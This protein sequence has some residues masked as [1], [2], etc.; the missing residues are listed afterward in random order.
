MKKLPILLASVLLASARAAHAQTP[1][2]PPQVAETQAAPAPASAGVA[3]EKFNFR[4][5][6]QQ[7]GS[8][9]LDL[10]A[11]RTTVGTAQAQN[12]LAR[13]FPDPTVTAG[14]LQYDLSQNG[15]NPTATVVQLNVPI[16]IG[17]QRGARIAYAEANLSA[18][19]A[20]L[21]DYL[22]TL[23][24]NAANGYVDSLHAR[25]ILERRKR[26]LASLSRLVAVNEERLRA[27]D[28]GE[29]T[30]LQSRVEANP[31]R[32]DCIDSEGVVKTADLTLVQLLGTGAATRMTR[33]INVEG[34]LTAAA[35]RTFD[36]AGL[37][38]I[39]N[40]QRP[41]L[42]AAKRRQSAA[43]RQIDLAKAN[44]V[45]DL[46]VGATWQHNLYL[47][48][49]SP[50]TPTNMLGGQVT[51]PIPFSRMYR[52]EL[53]AAYAQRSLSEAVSQGTAVRVEIEVRSAVAKYEAAAGRVK[54]Y[55]GG[56]IH[57]ADQV[58][59]KALYNYQRGGATLVEVLVA[60]RTDNDVY[61]SYYDALADAAHALIAVQQAAGTWDIEL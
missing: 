12:A 40:A 11:Q 60:Q 16:Q 5:Y 33:A 25:L 18:T 46:G 21:M 43:S 57:D 32:A 17:G 42:L 20:E 41:D 49:A 34:N 36:V 59:E 14:L 35:D 48:G 2:P 47:G 54:L 19:E 22:R 6:L 55:T 27:G 52:G 29:A 30:V 1:A 45:V 10:L 56:T 31:F 15:Q 7:V 53:D 8:G 26:T 24:A 38:Q 61:L 4:G 39:A 50:Q 37:I 28:I 9:N 58:L 51:V 23:R 13:I 3:G 44:R